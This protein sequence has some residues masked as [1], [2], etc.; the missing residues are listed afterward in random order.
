MSI[1]YSI[2]GSRQNRMAWGW[3]CLFAARLSRH[4][5]AG[6]G[7]SP[8]RPTVPSF[9]LCCSPTV[10]RLLVLH[11]ES[12]PTTSRLVCVSDAEE[13]ID[14]PID[15]LRLDRRFVH[16]RIRIGRHPVHEHAEPSHSVGLLR[17]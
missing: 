1:G 9:N 11:E 16:A 3:A 15:I 5:M 12:N 2:H 8:T 17:P 14:D 13:I 4:I 6:Y 10:R 7:L